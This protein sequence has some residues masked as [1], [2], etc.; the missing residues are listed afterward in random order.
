[1]IKFM[2]NQNQI[3]NVIQSMQT[4][5]LMLFKLSSHSSSEWV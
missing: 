1:M 4:E 5:R 2:T 3:K